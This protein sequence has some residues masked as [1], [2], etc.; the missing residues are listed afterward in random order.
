MNIFRASTLDEV[1]EAIR[2]REP[3]THSN[4]QGL[5]AGDGAPFQQGSAFADEVNSKARDGVRVY[6]VT[7]YGVPVVADA[8]G[9]ILVNPEKYS[10]TTTR[11]AN[12]A[13][14]ALEG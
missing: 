5:F 13:K 6:V 1:A 14:Q 10:T 9:E 12:L 4:M 2:N 8:D 3:F 7:S 11:H